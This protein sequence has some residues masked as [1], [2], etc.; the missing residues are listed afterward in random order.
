[1]MLSVFRCP[2]LPRH[3]KKIGIIAGVMAGFTLLNYANGNTALR[4]AAMFLNDDFLNSLAPALSSGISMS[5]SEIHLYPTE[6]PPTPSTLGKI[7]QGILKGE[8]LLYR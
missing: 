6:G 1:M 4:C 5:E 7:G 2:R 8:V 3:S